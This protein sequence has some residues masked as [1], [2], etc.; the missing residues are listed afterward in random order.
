MK[1][2]ITRCV[3]VLLGLGAIRPALAAAVASDLQPD[4]L[5]LYRTVNGLELKLH[6]FEPA[7][8]KPSDR[9]AA[10]VFFSAAAGAAATQSSF[11][12]TPER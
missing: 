6:T 4:R 8:L 7:G 2:L 3:A 9:R 1:H 11:I 10:I 12:N 5:T